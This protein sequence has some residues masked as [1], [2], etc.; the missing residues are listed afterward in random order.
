MYSKGSAMPPFH[1]KKNSETQESVPGTV[2]KGHTAPVLRFIVAS[3][4]HYGYQGS[5]YESYYAAFVSEVNKLH[6]ARP[7]NF[8]MINGDIIHDDKKYFPAAK[9]ALDQLRLPYYVSQG[10]HDHATPGEWEAVWGMPLNFDF[11]IGRESF[12]VGTTSDEK[13]TYLCPDLGWMERALK[14]HTA[15]RN[16]FL[17]LHIN[18]AKQTRYAVDCPSLFKLLSRYPNVRAVF[19][20][21]DHD[22]DDIKV[23]EG[24]PFVFDAHFGGGGGWGTA[25]NGFRVVELFEDNTIA[26]FIHTPFK[27]LNKD[28]L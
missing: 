28:S 20:G 16:V 2:I 17:F 1:S 24:I 8:C 27:M 6:A 11:S 7:F 4:G 9:K 21:H 15:Q 12:L 13:G 5:P 19:N 23:R 14:K 18:P 3:D 25:Y 10:N 26:T 22:E